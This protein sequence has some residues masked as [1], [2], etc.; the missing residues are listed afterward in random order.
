M[1][2]KKSRMFIIMGN[3]KCGQLEPAVKRTSY[4]ALQLYYFPAQIIRT[5]RKLK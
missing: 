3:C 2:T 4:M 5:Y 1:Y